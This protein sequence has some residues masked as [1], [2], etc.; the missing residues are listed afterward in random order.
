VQVAQESGKERFPR[1]LPQEETEKGI[2]RPTHSEEGR[3]R[4]DE[5][6]GSHR[7]GDYTSGE[8]VAEPAFPCR[9][10]RDIIAP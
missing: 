9:V 2:E 5:K 4:G 7:S 10:R 8:K 3:N 1:V 6:G